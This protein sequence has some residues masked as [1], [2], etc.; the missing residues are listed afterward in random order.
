MGLRFRKSIGSGP[1]RINFSGSG[2]ST[3]FGVKGARVNV[4]L[5][6]SR[7]KPR[8]TVGIPGSGL[9]YSQSLGANQRRGRVEE[10]P[11]NGPATMPEENK[12]IMKEAFDRAAQGRSKEMRE[13]MAFIVLI[14]TQHPEYSSETCWMAI[15]DQF[16]NETEDRINFG[17]GLLN[18][19]LA[20]VRAEHEEAAE[21]KAAE[22]H[23]LFYVLGAMLGFCLLLGTVA[24]FFTGHIGLALLLGAA[25]W[26]IKTVSNN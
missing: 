17:L 16:P 6:G 4:P 10:Q 24:A 19:E 13:L 21:A 23:H 18:D 9:S 11:Q 2:I 7:R 14:M 3:S 26:V 5:V 12:A 1:F 25:I 20:Q 22:W 8:L 15:K